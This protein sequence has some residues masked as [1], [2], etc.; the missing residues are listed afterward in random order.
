MT[1][2]AL[3]LDAHLVFDAAHGDGVAIAQRPLSVE[4][5]L[6]HKAGI[7]PVPRGRVGVR[8]STK[9]TMFSVRS[10]SPP[11]MKIL[12]PLTEKDPSPWGSARVRRRDRSEPAWLG[13]A[14]GAA[15]APFI[16][17]R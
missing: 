1:Q 5:K 6:R 10:C 16:E 2:V 12:L 15:E 17:G 4:Q 7:G 3:L 13:Q 9:C 8:A 11:V 14:H